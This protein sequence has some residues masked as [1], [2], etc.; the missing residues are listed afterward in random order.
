MKLLSILFIVAT[1]LIAGCGK[2]E[3]DDEEVTSVTGDSNE[4]E[5]K[6]EEKEEEKPEEE[7]DED[8]EEKEEPESAGDDEIMNPQLAE[9]TDGDVEVIFTND[10][11]GYT[12][13]LDGLEV[14]VHKYQIVKITD[15]NKSQDIVFDENL[16]G[17][18]VSIDVITDNTREEHVIFNN[19]IVISEV[20]RLML[21]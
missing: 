3:K 2:D 5:D 1:M 14:E 12:S 4:E 18:T 19:S 10:D 17:Y 15:M 20:H 7:E 8:K 9:E 6:E 16:E 21:I 13:D 11:P